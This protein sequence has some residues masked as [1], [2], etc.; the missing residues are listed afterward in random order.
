MDIL[1]MRQE[2]EQIIESIEVLK[3]I[4]YDRDKRRGR[5][6]SWMTTAGGGSVKRHGRPSGSKNKRQ[7]T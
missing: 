1:K 5:P 2:R 4:A 6:P 7:D 3:R